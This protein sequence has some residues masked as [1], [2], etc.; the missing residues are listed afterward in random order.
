MQLQ[1]ELLCFGFA[2]AMAAA[3]P[4]PTPAQLAWQQGGRWGI[5]A[6]VHFNMVRAMDE[7]LKF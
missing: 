4:L 6:L 3:P 1:I 2:A 7:G 5:S